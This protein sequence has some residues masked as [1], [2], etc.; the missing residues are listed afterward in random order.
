MMLT[1]V[2]DI[3]AW[4]RICD[5][6]VCGFEKIFTSFL[7][8]TTPTPGQ[9]GEWISFLFRCPNWSMRKTVVNNRAAS[10]SVVVGLETRVGLRPQVEHRVPARI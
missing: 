8:R 6:Y 4:L 3:E 1:L 9:T 10:V 2:D 7:F 5:V